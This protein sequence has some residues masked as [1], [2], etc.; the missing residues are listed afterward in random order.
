[1]L[2]L[3]TG[4]MYV[5]EEHHE[6]IRRLENAR[7]GA[8][9]DEAMLTGPMMPVTSCWKVDGEWC[10]VAGSVNPVAIV[11]TSEIPTEWDG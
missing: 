2:V 5:G 3:G 11:W 1:M 10:A 9:S 7:F 8:H 6:V 4:P